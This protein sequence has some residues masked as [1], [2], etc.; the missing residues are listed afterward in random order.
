MPTP[1]DFSRY[2]FTPNGST[3][4]GEFGP[5]ASPAQGLSGANPNAAGLTPVAPP[6]EPSYPNI[7]GYGFDPT[8]S[9]FSTRPEFGTE[10]ESV[11]EILQQQTIPS[12]KA[13]ADLNEAYGLRQPE[14][15]LGSHPWLRDSLA[16]PS[17]REPGNA[18]PTVD[19][20]PFAEGQT[21]SAPSEL[22]T[23][24]SS[25]DESSLAFEP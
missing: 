21:A 17:E 9:Q 7:R 19:K 11:V 20:T 6:P 23:P 15:T 5:V 4:V 25:G 8:N 10:Q 16:D 22:G 2:D 3:A 13:H 12:I 1:N 18:S 24:T 14:A